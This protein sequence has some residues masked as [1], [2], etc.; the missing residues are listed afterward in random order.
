MGMNKYL[1]FCKDDQQWVDYVNRHEKLLCDS[2]AIS[3]EVR[4]NSLIF[5]D[6]YNPEDGR[7]YIKITPQT[8]NTYVPIYLLFK[9]QIW[10]CDKGEFV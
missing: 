3:L 7:I 2:L 9:E 1:V 8:V 10:L 6:V 5:H 4:D